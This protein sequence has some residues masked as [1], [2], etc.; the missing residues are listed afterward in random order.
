MKPPEPVPSPNDPDAEAIADHA[1]ALDMLLV[2]GALWPVVRMLPANAALRLTLELARHPGATLGRAGEL[3]EELARIAMGRSELVPEPKDR[4]FADE[5]WR[6]NPVLR[7]LL[8]AYLATSD[9]GAD[10]VAKADVGWRDRERLTFA[11]DNLVAAVAPSNNP[12]L[13]PLGWR[14]ATGS[15]GGSALTGARHL[16][17]D[18][19]SSPRVPTMVPS[20]A[21]EVGKD[22]A[23]T[24][25]T[26]VLRTE[27]FELIQYAPRTARVRGRPLVVVPPVINK[28]YIADLRPGRSLVE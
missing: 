8:Q 11:L 21:F 26:V 15:R 17:G 2:D 25:G 9:A 16:I 7:R 19:I 18:L 4:R 12:L 10:L 22:L 23:L 20:D 3:A 13:N 1:V 6:T 14:A 5:A 24:P 27:V 28:F